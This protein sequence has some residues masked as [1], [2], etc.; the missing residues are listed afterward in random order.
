MNINRD[1][2]EM[3]FLLYVDNELSVQERDAVEKFVIENTDLKKEL[4]LL[5]QTALPSEEIIFSLKKG[6][7]KTEI[8][9]ELRE[10][11]LLH[12]DNELDH[13]LIASLETA[14][15]SDNFVKEEWN[16]LLKTKLEPDENIVFENKAL[17]YRHERSN[18]ISSHFRRLAIAAAIL[19]AGL[20]IGIALFTGNKK[21]VD[22]AVA[23]K[24]QPSSKKTIQLPK[25]IEIPVKDHNNEEARPAENLAATGLSSKTNTAKKNSMIISD[26]QK[27]NSATQIV[28][29][30]TNNLPK[31][32]FENINNRSSN[33]VSSPDVKDNIK[34]LQDKSEELAQTDQHDIPGN[35]VKE[36][37]IPVN[38]NTLTETPA[39]YAKAAVLAETA[40]ETNNNH[41]LFLSEDKINRSKFSGFFRKVKRVVERNTNIQTGGS[42]KIAGFEVAAR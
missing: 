41:I 8:S 9:K 14:I 13:S 29:R 3:Y 23:Q 33:K 36:P 1:N 15:V 27:N 39:S 17:L 21:N 30:E 2:Y 26:E 42:L 6:L 10:N 20:F 40:S 18:V 11:M 16:T 37:L 22:V 24:D 28:K 31:P 4:E 34:N 35:K 19:G 25:A 7:Y 32:Y 5:M 12:L 38:Y